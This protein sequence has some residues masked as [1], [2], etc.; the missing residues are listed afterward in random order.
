MES[1][2]QVRRR[3][4]AARAALT[5]ADLDAAGRGIAAQGL[6]WAASLSKR[7]ALFSAYLGVG[8]EPPTMPLLEALHS[9]GHRILLPICEPERQLSWT[10]WFPGMEMARSRFAPL[11][12]P[13]GE[14][15]NATA[16]AEASGVILPATAV[17][18]SGQ[19]IGQGGGYYDRF[20]A[21]LRS[22]GIQ[23]PT[24]AVTFASEF[25]SDARIPAE[26]FDYPVDAVITPEGIYDW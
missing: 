11:W 20:L 15:L 6:A 24:A 17:D 21:K 26:E 13:V 5:S 16:F 25:L 18:G 12:E 8:Y 2:E 19:R 7:P 14:R 22:H 3:H 23:C 9:T 10:L 4:W 1:K